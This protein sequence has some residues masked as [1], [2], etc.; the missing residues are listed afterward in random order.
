MRTFTS[1]STCTFTSSFYSTLAF[2]VRSAP[3]RLPAGYTLVE[4]LLVMAVAGVLLAMA[5]PSMSGMLGTQ[6]AASLATRFMASLHL[7]RSEAIKRNGRAVVCKSS[8][9][10]TCT[11]AG[12]WEQG[13]IVFHDANN[14][15]ALDGGEHIV[16][17]HAGSASVIRL[18]GNLPV[19]NYVS[20]ASNGSAKLVSGAFQAGT[21]T[22]CPLSASAIPA[23]KIIL[24][25]TGR[26]R[27]QSGVA[28]DCS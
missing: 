11:T 13:W 16:L 1:P 15:A 5:L 12:G 23:R 25:G 7:A 19:S 3:S 27:A 24:S 17:Q 10:S 21:F 20:Y 8:S 4:L 14:N 26:P 6:R 28:G 22:L 9:G 2:Q 18:T